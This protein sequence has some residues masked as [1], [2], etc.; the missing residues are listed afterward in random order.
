MKGIQVSMLTTIENDARTRESTICLIVEVV[1]ILISL[2][3]DDETAEAGYEEKKVTRV[4]SSTSEHPDPMVPPQ[5]T[6]L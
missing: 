5:K 3:L 2:H 6:R 1:Y 4:I